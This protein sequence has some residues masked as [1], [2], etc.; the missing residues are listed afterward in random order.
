M[1]TTSSTKFPLAHA[2][3]LNNHKTV[4][5][6]LIL[7]LNHVYNEISLDQ[8]VCTIMFNHCFNFA[9]KHKTIITTKRMYWVKEFFTIQALVKSDNQSDKLN[10]RGEAHCPI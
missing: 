4:S 6:H 2:P 3:L 10:S 5:S 7:N 1:C 8:Q 9:H